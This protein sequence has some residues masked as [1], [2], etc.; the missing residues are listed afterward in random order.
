MDEAIELAE[1]RARLLDQPRRR[2]A[3]GEV[4][5]QHLRFGAGLPRRRR[6]ALGVVAVAAGVDGERGT[7]RG[8]APAQCWRR[9]P[10]RR[11]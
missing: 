10:S 9:C 11:R 4:A 8:E 2:A 3:F 5:E 6:D 7:R 1:A